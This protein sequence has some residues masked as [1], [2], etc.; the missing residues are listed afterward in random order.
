MNVA[1]PVPVT[2]AL[3]AA[4]GGGRRAAARHIDRRSIDTSYSSEVSIGDGCGPWY[5][6]I[7]TNGVKFG[8]AGNREPELFANTT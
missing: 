2:A 5:F 6:P 3:A 8:D 7:A 4:D 1:Y